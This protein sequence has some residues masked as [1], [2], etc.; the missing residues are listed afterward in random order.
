MSTMAGLDVDTLV[1]NALTA[2]RQIE[3]WSEARINGLLHALANVVADHAHRLAVDTVVETGMGNVHD[4]TFKNSIASVG[5]SAFLAG[6]IGQGEIGFDSEC[7]VA[8]IA[9]PVGVV[10]GL[11]PATHPVA[12][13]IFKVLIALK[14]RNAIILS[15]SRR[16]QRVSEHVGQMIREKLREMGAPVD[17]V[18]WLGAGSTR[19]TVATLMSDEHIGVVLATGG[20]AMVQ[21]AYRSGRPAIGVGPGNAPVLIGADA[22][23]RH[24]AHSVV[25]SKSFDNGLICGA[26][27][28]LV[29]HSAVRAQ[30]LDELMRHRVAVLT[31]S[32]RARLHEVVVNVDTLRFTPAFAGRDAATLASLARIERPYRIA[33]LVVP[34]QSVA[35]AGYLAFEK[36]APV[37]SLFTVA[38]MDEGMTVC[39]ALLEID[40]AGHTA[41]VHTRNGRLI[42]RFAAGIPAS[43]ILVNSPATQG[44][45]GLTTGLTPSL[46]LGCGTWGG[47]STTNSVTYRDLLNIKR[48]AYYRPEHDDE[49]PA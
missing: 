11:V 9:S 46:T 24:V 43:R 10:A 32:E 13:F 33:L 30:L 4:K 36:L 8:E 34:V 1:A 45:M 5:V 31:Q 49:Y 20:R 3:S 7:G 42:D 12:T 22:D 29:V 28:H 35:D 25:I 27:N 47:T 23:L 2:Q 19:Q 16:A 48:V 14:G 40:G 15:P 39:R 17:L 37:M 18:Q 21:A 41:V 26:E 44:L 6:H 38:D